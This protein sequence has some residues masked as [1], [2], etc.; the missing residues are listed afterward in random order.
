[1]GNLPSTI[2]VWS[3]LATAGATMSI[4]CAPV[5]SHAGEPTAPVPPADLIAEAQERNPEIRALAAAIAS[6]QGEVTTAKTW[7]NPELGVAPGFRNTR[8][9]GGSYSSEFHGTLDL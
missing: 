4:F 6:A 1:M 8:P 3:A 2:R 5:H 7:D 9:A